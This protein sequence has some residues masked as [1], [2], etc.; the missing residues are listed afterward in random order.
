MQK[1]FNLLMFSTSISLCLAMFSLHSCKENICDDP[2]AVNFEANADCLFPELSLDIALKVGSQ[3]LNYEDTYTLNGTAVQFNVA[4]F[5]L[6]NFMLSRTDEGGATEIP[7]ENS[8]LL[9][10]PTQQQ[11]N[12]GTITSGDFEQLQFN[13]GIDPTAN[14]Q[15]ETDFTQRAADDPLAAQN[16]AMHWNWNTGY[17]FIR[18]DLTVDAD[19]DGTPETDTQMH[20]GSNNLLRQVD[21]SLTATVNDATE[22]WT[23][24]FDLGQALTGI[25]FSSVPTTH[26]ANNPALANQIADGLMSAATVK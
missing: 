13:I 22:T 12:L 19:G 10:K 4:Q 7:I 6:S 3:D 2:L 11:Y 23:L 20:V 24:E 5:Y 16:P 21:Q 15:T 26:T 18:L 25:D 9:V 8:Y 14:S 1:L 17:K